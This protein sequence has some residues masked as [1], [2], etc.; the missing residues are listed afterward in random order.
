MR[1]VELLEA[2]VTFTAADVDKA[3]AE[4]EH[5][6]IY[7][8][9]TGNGEIHMKELYPSNRHNLA[10]HPD[11]SWRRSLKMTVQPKEKKINFYQGSAGESLKPKVQQA[12]RALRDAGIIDDTWHIE[13]TH[14]TGYYPPESSKFTY[15]RNPVDEKG[16]DHLADKAIRLSSVTQNLVLYHGTS[17]IDWEKI[18]KVGLHPLGFGSNTMHGPESRSKHEGNA[19][20]LYLAGSIQKA[21]SYGKL[22]VDFWNTKKHGSPHIYGRDNDVVVLAV[23]IPDIGKLVVDDDVVIRMAQNIARKLW[24]TKSIEERQRIATEIGLQRGFNPSDDVAQLLWRETEQGFTEIFA[25]I[26]PRIF[27]TWK[28]SLFR[29]N[30]VGYKGF[31]P[32]KFLKR[33][34]FQ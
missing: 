3:G 8:T 4:S 9:M 1:F 16:L 20:V 22:R 18:Q 23:Q 28:S 21:Y 14:E 19:K 15:K 13:T 33:V 25:K 30:Q 24:K 2:K 26:P 10:D 5:G 11:V 34:D 6:V 31:I 32:P 27:K 17:M 12:L 29:E 7:F